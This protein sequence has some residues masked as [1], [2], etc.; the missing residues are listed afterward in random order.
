MLLAVPGTSLVLHAWRHAMAML[1]VD[2]LLALWKHGWKGH[3]AWLSVASATARLVGH[4]CFLASGGSRPRLQAES[5]TR[6]SLPNSRTRSTTCSRGPILRR[7][8]PLLASAQHSNN[9]RIKKMQ[10][11]ETWVDLSRC[12]AGIW[13]SLGAGKRLTCVGEIGLHTSSVLTN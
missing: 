7:T 6:Q 3:K 2:C 9:I 8:L 5:A 13:S 1:F 12:G 4:R 11:E 10:P